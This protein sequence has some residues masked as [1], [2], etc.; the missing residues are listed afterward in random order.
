MAYTTGREASAIQAIVAER[1]SINPIE[2]L[3]PMQRSS[4]GSVEMTDRTGLESPALSDKNQGK[5]DTPVSPLDY[6][7]KLD[8]KEHMSNASE[9]ESGD[10]PDPTKLLEIPWQYKWLA[11]LCACAFPIGLNCECS[12]PIS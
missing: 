5:V 4:S 10:E 9:L 3:P 11:L 12:R 7:Q 1:H 8:V 2:S 6:V